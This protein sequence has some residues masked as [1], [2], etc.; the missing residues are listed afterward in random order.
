MNEK[1]INPVEKMLENS[2]FCEDTI[3]YSTRKDKICDICSGIIPK[4]S[5]HIGA[6]LFSDEYYQVN[7]CNSCKEA[8]FTELAAMRNKE[9]DTF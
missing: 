7:F 3:V 2:Y 8:F 9:Y 5:A 4:G 6:K 1:L